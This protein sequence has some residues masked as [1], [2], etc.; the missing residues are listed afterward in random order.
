MVTSLKWLVRPRYDIFDKK[1]TYNDDAR[2]Y[3]VVRALG[4]MKTLYK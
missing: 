2:I 3:G 4:G 1:I